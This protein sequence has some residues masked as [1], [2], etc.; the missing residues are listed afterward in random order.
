MNELD[1][2]VP[3]RGPVEAAPRPVRLVAVV[4]GLWG[5]VL[6]T[7]PREVVSLVQPDLVRSSWAPAIVRVLGGRHVGQAVVTAALPSRKLSVAGALVDGLHAMTALTYAASGRSRRRAGLSSASMAV[8]LG[9]AGLVASRLDG[10]QS[11]HGDSSPPALSVSATSRE[12]QPPSTSAPP[13]SVRAATHP[14][15]TDSTEPRRRDTLGRTTVWPRPM[16]TGVALAI[17]GMATIALAM[18]QGSGA[19]TWIGVGVLATGLLAAWRSG[20]LNDVQAT[21]PMSHELHEAMEGG[22][23]PGVAAGE[24]I[25]DGVAKQHARDT[26]MRTDHLLA[27]QVRAPAPP[28]RPAAT[29]VLLLLGGW[30]FASTFLVLHPYTVTGQNSALRDLGFAIIVTLSALWLRHLGANRAVSAVAVL[31]GVLLVLSA[32]LLPYDNQAVA[33]VDAVN[34]AAVTLAAMLATVRRGDE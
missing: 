26:T 20:V 29:L 28:V 1:R 8:G 14:E 32:F 31:A 3:V 21:Q 11:R 2:H 12:P 24:Q 9:V 17:I 30:I 34:G 33:A 16:W 23:Y 15:S 10:S 7:Q 6:L 27:S 25:Q 19:W 4:R 18:T 22:T 13:G 5:T